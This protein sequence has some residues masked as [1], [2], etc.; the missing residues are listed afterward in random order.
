M[1]TKNKLL[2]FDIDATL[3]KSEKIHQQAFIEALRELGVTDINT[4]WETYEHHTDSYIAGV[5]YE[6]Q[7]GKSMGSFDLIMMEAD[8]IEHMSTHK[9]VS[10]V[11]GA[12]A[13][14]SHLWKKT[15]YAIAFATGSLREPALLK[16]EE[17]GIRC[18]EG[19]LAAANKHQDR[20]SIVKEAIA[21]A[22]QFYKVDEF[23]EI[24]AF[25]DGK[26]DF[27]TASEL[28]LSFIAVGLE[29][30][31]WFEEQGV[32]LWIENYT[33]FGVKELDDFLGK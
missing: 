29:Q 11:P 32:A 17:A 26:W 14:I 22:K 8:M 6:K 30:K 9:K 12:A 18:E 24:V 16:L 25:G 1:K 15:D 19:V 20:V 10:E 21:S 31:E 2:V 5:N 33:S 27:Q 28:G 3:T 23:D 13:M 4:D 7:F